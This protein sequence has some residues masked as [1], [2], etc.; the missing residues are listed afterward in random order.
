MFHNDEILLPGDR[1]PWG[2][3]AFSGDAKDSTFTHNGVLRSSQTML[4]VNGKFAVA[5]RPRFFPCVGDLVYGVVTDVKLERAIV[6]IM[7]FHHNQ[8]PTHPRAL[9]HP[10]HGVIQQRDASP[11]RIMVDYLFRINDIVRGSVKEIR[12]GECILQT[13]HDNEVNPSLSFLSLT[14]VCMLLY[15]CI[16]S[17]V[18]HCHSM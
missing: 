8:Y 12:S 17:L 9:T 5:T 4:S 6:R 7:G 15:F 18:E 13:I 3:D 16:S 1:A 14:F 10:I 2:S 11:N